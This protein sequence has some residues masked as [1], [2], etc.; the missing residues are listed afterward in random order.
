MTD[1]SLPPVALLLMPAGFVIWA[2]AF[3]MLYAA[4]A[5]GCA[6][7][8]AAGPHRAGLLLIWALHVVAVSAL[9]VYCLRLPRGHSDDLRR[10]L[11][12]TAVGCTAAALIA[13]VLTGIMIP[14]IS[15]CH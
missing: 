9:L 7:D 5:V 8:L 12:V 10:F 13:T 6:I 4:Q 3:A 14:V 11:R 2:S 15:L 1:R